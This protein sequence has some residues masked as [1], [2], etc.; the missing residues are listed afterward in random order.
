[1]RKVEGLFFFLIGSTPV[2]HDST[3]VLHIQDSMSNVYL[4]RHLAVIPCVFD[5]SAAFCPLAFCPSAFFPPAFCPSA[6]F[7]PQAAIG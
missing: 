1:M 6:F 4:L 2:L 5:S 3:S 7:P